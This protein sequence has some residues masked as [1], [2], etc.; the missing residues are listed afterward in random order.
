MEEET[1]KIELSNRFFA[2]ASVLTAGLIVFYI[3][4]AVYQLLT[5]PQNYPQD[6]VITGEG[7]AY[8]KPDVAIAKLGVKTEAVKSGDAV[9]KNNEAM[10]K[11]IQAVKDLGVEEKDIQTTAYNLTPVYDYTEM[12]RIFKGYSLEQQVAVKIRNFEKIGDVLDGASKNGA[13]TIGDLQFTI[14]DPETA[15]AEAR[16]KAVDQAK[17][18]AQSLADDAG[19]RIVKLVNISE[20]YN[21]VPPIYGYGGG[22]MMEKASAIPQIESGQ[23]EITASVYLTYRVK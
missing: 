6:I 20:G 1:K 23:L 8:A 13:N 12:G 4:Q 9:N 16:K 3:G 14:D 17:A 7:K 10:N 11:I 18:K 2:L 21:D 15:R 5:L 22:V 19:L